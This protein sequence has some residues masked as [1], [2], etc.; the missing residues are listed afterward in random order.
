MK[1]VSLSVFAALLLSGCQTGTYMSSAATDGDGVT[2]A[3]I[4]QAFQ[5][6]EQDRQSAAAWQQLSTLIS[7]EAGAVAARGA[8]KA[9]QYYESTKASVNLALAVRGCQPVQ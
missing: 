6:Y 4:Y 7:P 8:E 9:A 5:T 1:S 2:C 3:E